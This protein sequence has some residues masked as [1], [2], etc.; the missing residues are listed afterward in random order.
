MVFLYRLCHAC[1]ICHDVPSFIPLV[2]CLLL[3]FLVGLEVCQLYWFFFKDTAISL[4]D[5]C[6]GLDVCTPSPQFI[7]GDL[8]PN[9]MVFGGGAL[10]RRWGHE[11]GALISGTSALV[12]EA[13]ERPLAPSAIWCYLWE[14]SQ[15]EDWVSGWKFPLSDHM[16]DK[17]TRVFAFVKFHTPD[18]E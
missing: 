3:V 2:I 14:V 7:C 13:P 1:G 9:V 8:I 6:H 12:K 18:Q 4:I 17:S 10:G 16:I 11:G 5:H 15:N